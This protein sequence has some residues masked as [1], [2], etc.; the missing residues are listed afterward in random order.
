M[1]RTRTVAELEEDLVS[2]E[3]QISQL[4]CEQHVLVSQLDKAQAPKTDG[5]NA[6]GV[7]WELLCISVTGIGV[8]AGPS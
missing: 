4:R 8:G 5:G 3:A 2:V 1:Y 7:P 6:F